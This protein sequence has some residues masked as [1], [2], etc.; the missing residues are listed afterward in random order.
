MRR[1]TAG[2]EWDTDEALDRQFYNG[3]TDRIEVWMSHQDSE[4]CNPVYPE[5]HPAAYRVERRWYV[6]DID[7]AGR[8]ENYCAESLALADYNKR[9]NERAAK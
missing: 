1:T 7:S 3:K 5:G 4:V 9:V 8:V 2:V 6:W